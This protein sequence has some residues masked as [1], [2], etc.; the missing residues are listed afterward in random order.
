MVAG[1]GLGGSK[2]THPS[3]VMRRGGAASTRKSFTAF[4]FVGAGADRGCR[5]HPAL[6]TLVKHNV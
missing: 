5:A 6:Q 2:G 4:G 1:G 3:Q